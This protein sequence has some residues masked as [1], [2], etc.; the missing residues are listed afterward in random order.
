MSSL[1]GLGSGEQ[2]KRHENP[3]KVRRMSPEQ[4][5]DPSQRANSLASLPGA[6]MTQFPHFE[7]PSVFSVSSTGNT[8]NPTVARENGPG[9]N[10]TKTQKTQLLH[11]QNPPG[12][13]GPGL[14]A[15]LTGPG[16][17]HLLLRDRASLDARSPDSFLQGLVAT[18]SLF[19]PS[20]DS[21]S[22][23]SV[24]ILVASV[25]PRSVTWSKVSPPPARE[26][27]RC[28][29]EDRR[30]GPHGPLQLPCFLAQFL[31]SIRPQRGEEAVFVSSPSNLP[32]N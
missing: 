24:A 10:E 23:P 7:F 19:Y 17:W 25:D 22:H 20:G 5:S 11:S 1:G 21:V 13:E 27:G 4:G 8:P 29:R 6:L 9:R 3:T 30:G 31:G 12:E 32:N 14:S 2:G 16:M 26:G 18:P 15:W 28:L